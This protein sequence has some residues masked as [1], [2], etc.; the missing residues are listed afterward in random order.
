VNGTEPIFD[1][2]VSQ[3]SLY[4]Q[5]VG[6]YGPALAR[7]ARAYEFNPETRRDLLQEIHFHLWRSFSNFDGRC[8]LRTWVYRVAHNVAMGHVVRQRRNRER[9]VSLETIESTTGSEQAEVAA[10]R[11]EA[12][13]C[14]SMLVQRLKPLDRQII[15]SYLEGM[16]ANSIAEITGLTTPNTAMKIHGIKNILRRWFN[17]G[18]RHAK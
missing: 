14:L 4:E 12:M 15:V 13:E 5:V 16:D 18:G 11:A 2:D 6:A 1:Q 17:G 7:L 10:S 9:L 3:D 8:L